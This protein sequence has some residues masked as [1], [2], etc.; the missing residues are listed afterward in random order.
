MPTFVGIASK[1]VQ[2][3]LAPACCVLRGSLRSRLSMRR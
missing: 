2:R 3:L 1:D